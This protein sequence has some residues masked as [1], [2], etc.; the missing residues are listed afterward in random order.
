[1]SEEEAVRMVSSVAEDVWNAN[2]GQVRE[3]ARVL[4]SESGLPAFSP[5]VATLLGKLIAKVQHE[6][7]LHGSM[8]T[9]MTFLKSGLALKDAAQK[10]SVQ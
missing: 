10:G 7:F 8:L 3:L 5:E 6:S 4:H 1:M 9:T 2:K